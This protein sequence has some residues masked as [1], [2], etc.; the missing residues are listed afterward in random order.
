M[1]RIEGPENPR[2]SWAGSN[3]GSLAWHS[4]TPCPQEATMFGHLARIFL[5][6]V[7][8]SEGS[9]FSDLFAFRKPSPPG[10]SEVCRAGERA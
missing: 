9:H 6:S 8:K 1:A 3:D 4:D 2:W 7:V 5:D 10:R